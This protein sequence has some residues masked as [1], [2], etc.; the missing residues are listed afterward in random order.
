[1]DFIGFLRAFQPQLMGCFAVLFLIALLYM[2]ARY[3]ISKVDIDHDERQSARQ[4]TNR[5]ASIIVVVVLVITFYN[6]VEVAL[7][8]RMPRSDV[9]KEK[10]GVYQQMRNLEK[11]QK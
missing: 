5:I 8:D 1:M 3:S 11:G 4:W 7:T 10:A 2:L 6:A 9:D